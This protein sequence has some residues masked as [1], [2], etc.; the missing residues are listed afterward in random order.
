MQSSVPKGQITTIALRR[1][2]HNASELQP[3]D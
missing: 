3:H 2:A 1:R